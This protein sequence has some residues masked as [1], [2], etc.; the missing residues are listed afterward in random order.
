MRD[1]T[2]S[3]IMHLGKGYCRIIPQNFGSKID[4]L[5]HL[6]WRGEKHP[7]LCQRRKT[8]VAEAS[9]KLQTQNSHHMCFII[10]IQHGDF[11]KL[12]F[13]TNHPFLASFY[14]QTQVL[15]AHLLHQVFIKSKNKHIYFPGHKKEHRHFLW[16]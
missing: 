13:Y 10:L 2:R 16:I 6:L 7:T 9:Q 15:F 4:K 5:E 8:N 14:K 1:Q 12:Y 3:S 11:S